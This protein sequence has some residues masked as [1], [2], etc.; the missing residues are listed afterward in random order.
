MCLSIRMQHFKSEDTLNICGGESRL[1]IK[2]ERE[3]AF[4]VWDSKRNRAGDMGHWVGDKEKEE[5]V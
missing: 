3:E 5:E 4:I 1:R 2:G